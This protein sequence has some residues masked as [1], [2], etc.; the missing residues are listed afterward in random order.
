M[1]VLHPWIPMFLFGVLGL[2]LAVQD[3]KDGAVSLVLL[4]SVVVVW[5][6]SALLTPKPEDHLLA[7]GSV[8]VV[9]ALLLLVFPGRLGEADIVFMAGMA[10]MFTF[11]PLIICF[12]LACFASF[13]A[14]FWLFCKLGS[15]A[16]LY[17]LPFLP[18]LYWAGLT[19]SVGGMRF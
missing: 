5:W 3:Q 11:W 18:S 16:M 4:V 1:V 8:L 15:Q 13:V 7:A 10:S 9:G 17:P 6:S 19:I 14:Y 2:P 12:A